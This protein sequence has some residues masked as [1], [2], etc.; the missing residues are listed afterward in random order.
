MSRQGNLRFAGMLLLALCAWLWGARHTAEAYEAIEVKA[1]GSITGMVKFVGTPPPPEALE[2]TR[3][4]EVCG[5]GTRPSETLVVSGAGGVKNVVVSLTDIEKGKAQPELPE[6][7]KIE[8]EKCWFNPHVLLVPA[9]GTVDLYNLDKTTHNIRTRS[10]KNRLNKAHP[11]RKKLLQFKLRKPEV[12]KFS[13]SYHK[14]MSGW[15]VITEHPYYAVTDAKGAFS[16]QDVPPGTYTLQAWHETLGT[17]VQEVEV[18]A[19]GKAN[20]TFEMKP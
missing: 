13:C 18:S 2:I 1:G 10:K 19:N 3:D 12:V 16:L 14:W 7:P 11:S 4:E 5:T 20:I 9:G 15:F 6:N 8:Q 17:Q